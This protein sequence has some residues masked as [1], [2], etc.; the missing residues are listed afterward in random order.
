[1]KIC[2]AQIRPF[3]G[4]IQ[5]NIELHQQLIQKAIEEEADAIFFSEL[6]L[7]GFEPELAK[8]LAIMPNDARLEIFQILSDTHHLTIG[9]GLPIKSEAGVLISMAIFQPQKT[10]QIYSKQH[11]HPD[12]F[13]YFVSGSEPICLTLKDI[14][15]AIGICYETL[16]NIH[17]KA[18][19]D[20]KVQVYVA[21]VAKSQKGI[22][23]AWA[24][25][26]TIAKQYNLSVMM[27]N[28]IGFCDNFESVGQ[29][30][31]WN[32]QGMLMRQL[33]AQDEG[34]LIWD[35]ATQITLIK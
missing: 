14:K 3:K 20:S 33:D 15:I 23:K 1:M 22:E 9:V 13:P 18:A 31:V 4:D 26:P 19:F 21:S 7:M 30:A 32:Q 34:L 16:L 17:A 35:T 11:L 10:R 6:S 8:E 24:H 2:A 5:K 12:E 27:V 25:Y 28:C 29:T